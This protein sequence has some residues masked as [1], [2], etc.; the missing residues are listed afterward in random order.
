MLQVTPPG[1]IEKERLCQVK[2]PHRLADKGCAIIDKIIVWKTIEALCDNFLSLTINIWV[3]CWVRMN[4]DCMTIR[5]IGE[6][7]SRLSTEYS[8]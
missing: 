7:F 2:I 5:G 4:I 8:R 3:S 6:L 1:P